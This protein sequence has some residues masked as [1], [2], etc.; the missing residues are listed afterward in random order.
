M[1]AVQVHFAIKSVDVAMNAVSYG[2]YNKAVL[3][4][5]WPMGKEVNPAQLRWI[6]LQNMIRAM[7]LI[8]PH[9]CRKR[10]PKAESRIS[11]S[12]Q[13]VNHHIQYK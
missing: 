11:H 7:S 2:D 9:F 1:L 5:Q 3:K 13:A 8:V 4:S 12:S 6:K 10:T